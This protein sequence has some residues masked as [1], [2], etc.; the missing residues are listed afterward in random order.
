MTRQALWGIIKDAWKKTG[1]TRTISPHI[2]RHSIATHLLKK[3]A[4]L[5]SLQMLLGHETISTVQVYTHVE[6]SHLRI[7]YDKKHPRS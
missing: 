4:H 7:V 3:G 2:L 6:T 1:N 5:R